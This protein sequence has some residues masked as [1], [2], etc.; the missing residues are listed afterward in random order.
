MFAQTKKYASIISVQGSVLKNALIILLASVVLASI[1]QIAIH[2]WQPV[3]I[4][5]QSAM[6]VLL[7]LTLGS[8]R[9][10]AAVALYLFEG[11]VGL[12]VFAGGLSGFVYLAGP[13]AGYLWGFLPAA[14]LAGF[15][16]EKGM[17]KNVTTIFV[18][19]LLSATIIFLCGFLHLQSLIG[20]Q[21]AYIAGVK[22]FLAI[23]PVKLIGVSFLA[24]LCW[25]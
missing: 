24:K 3:P 12:P 4:S 8:K 25:K 18:T 17:A 7:G 6:V 11:L 23:E 20:F 10:A 5:L 1:S 13:S 14:F 2:L 22:P 15:L 19:A 9:A 16:M 21:N